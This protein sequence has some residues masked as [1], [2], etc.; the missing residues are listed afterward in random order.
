MLLKTLNNPFAKKMAKKSIKSSQPQPPHPRTQ[1]F[2]N[3][4]TCHNHGTFSKP[5]NYNSLMLIVKLQQTIGILRYV[6]PRRLTLRKKQPL[7][8]MHGVQYCTLDL[9][10][11][12]CNTTQLPLKTHRLRTNLKLSLHHFN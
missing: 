11:F 4:D 5:G 10:A 6:V 3:G 7:L 12:S 9:D 1:I 2:L 8:K